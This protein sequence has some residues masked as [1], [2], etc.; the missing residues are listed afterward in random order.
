MHDHLDA[1]SQV[2]DRGIMRGQAWL[3]TLPTDTT[4]RRIGADIARLADML[5]L[6]GRFDEAR[7][8]LE[9]AVE[10]RGGSRF[11]REYIGTLGVIAGMQGDRQRALEIYQDL[12]AQAWE[13]ATSQ[14]LWQAR[15]AASLGEIDKA[16]ALL[17]EAVG[18]GLPVGAIHFQSPLLWR[19]L[20][21]HPR[22]Q[23]L[24]RPKG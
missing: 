16:T 4:S 7:V 20:R 6:H 13:G 3:S 23:E 12:G 15:I 21:D 11:R 17:R 18:K 24:I 1:A 8:V 19:A 2:L 5:L 14:P 22:F 10:E 9:R